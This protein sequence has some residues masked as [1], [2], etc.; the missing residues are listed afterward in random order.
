MK[1]WMRDG[2]WLAAGVASFGIACGGDSSELEQT[3]EEPAPSEVSG[4]DQPPVIQHLRLE[5][6][7][8]LAGDRVR[9]QVMARD[10]EGERVELVYRW[11]V[12]GELQAE[13]GSELQL[14]DVS[15]GDRIE[16]E[17][18]A[19]DGSWETQA[20]TSV[21]VRNR[22]PVMVGVRLDPSPSVA[23]GQKLVAMAV[24]QDEDGDSIEYRYEWR[25]NG[26]PVEEGGPALDTAELKR[27]DEIQLHVRA[28]DGESDSDPVESIVVQIANANPEILSDPTG[29]REDGV[30]AYTIE[31]RDPDG[32]RNLRYS[33]PSAPE[34]MRVDSILGKVTWR[35]TPEQAGKHTVEVVVTDP[36]GAWTLQ[37]FELDV[38]LT[39][40]G[41]VPAARAP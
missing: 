8:P 5:P 11:S 33:L 12:A 30:F 15:R 34:G 24:G 6:A 26:R 18:T 17:V 41:G 29:F 38:A 31:A 28:N 19:T 39:E 10:P 16:V 35:P 22:R 2:R 20:S 3:L 25:V 21:E 32:D 14:G 36:Q 1:S 40:V 13:D 27:G 23:R 9:A 4:A 37:R 7:E